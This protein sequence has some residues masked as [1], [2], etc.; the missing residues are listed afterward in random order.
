MTKPPLVLH[1]AEE[2]AE[3]V[4]KAQREGSTI[5]L[6]PTMGNLHEG[7]LALVN[8]AGKEADLVVVSVFVNPLQFGPGEDF[9]RYPRTPDADL[10][11]L[12]G[13]GVAVVFAPGVEDVYPPGQT[14][15]A[16]S[17][18]PIG[19]LFEGAS[20]PGH[21]DGVL[22]VCHRLFALTGATIA[23]FGEKDAQ[24]LF[25][26]RQMVAT[27]M[28]TLRI[29]SVPTV[30]DTDGLALSS[31]NRYLSEGDRV[32]ARA[33]PETLHALATEIHGGADIATAL[34]AGRRRLKT[35]PGITLDYL[36]AVSASTFL[37]RDLGEGDTV[38]IAAVMV[39]TTRLIDNVPLHP[40]TAASPQ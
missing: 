39:G 5:A 31:R 28:P 18:G 16:M 19:N 14:A 4:E 37:P 17:A 12:Q 30:R 23:V 29:V 15:V 7:H 6:V 26:I 13:H 33:L 27:A 34:E 11:L 8:Q 21:F 38:I 25:L 3:F 40:G 22:T 35:T 9:E 32:T 1:S 2:M 10:E 36:E 24:Q 20:R